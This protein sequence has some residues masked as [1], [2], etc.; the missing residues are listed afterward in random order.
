MVTIYVLRCKHGKY[1][2][3]KTM[4]EVNIRLLEHLKRSNGASTEGGP[5]LSTSVAS[6]A[7]EVR[8]PPAATEGG[9]NRYAALL[10]KR[11]LCVNNHFFL[12][13][14]LIITRIFFSSFRISIHFI[15]VIIA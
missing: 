11:I 5:T 8:Q 13:A 10:V 6:L 1:Y 12:I 15:I 4:R 9:Q 3:G 14:K 2:V 7:N